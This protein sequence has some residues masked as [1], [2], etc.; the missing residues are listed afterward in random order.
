MSFP[1]DQ[2]LERRPKRQNQS[3]T[4]RERAGGRIGSDHRQRPRPARG[5]APLLT[6]RWSRP[7]VGRRTAPGWTGRARARRETAHQRRSNRGGRHRGGRA[8]ARMR[9]RPRY[10]R[11]DRHVRLVHGTHVVGSGCRTLRE[12]P[13]HGTHGTPK[14]IGFRAQSEPA[15]V[16]NGV[17]R[18]RGKSRWARESEV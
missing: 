16:N 2:R 10:P 17:V 5:S 7:V 15:S 14:P 12:H 4:G 18:A 13:C 6:M 9:G 11:L 1:R 8:S 3:A